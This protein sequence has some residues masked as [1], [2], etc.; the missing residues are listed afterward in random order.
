[1]D[2]KWDSVRTSFNRGH[3]EF[4]GDGR[5]T[6][7]FYNWNQPA[8]AYNPQTGEIDNGTRDSIGTSTVEIV[9][10]AQDS[11]IDVESGNDVEWSTS[12]R[13]PESDAVTSEFQP[14]GTENERPTEVELTDHKDDSTEVFELHSYTT[15]IGSGMI[16][17]RLQETD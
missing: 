7:E 15:E 11:T 3:T 16:M 5:Y 9:P 1:M 13:F 10:P 14:L 6:V 4:F 2:S 17:C 12:I 8:D